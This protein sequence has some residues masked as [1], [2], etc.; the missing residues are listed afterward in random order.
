MSTGS[1]P[2]RLHFLE[3]VAQLKFKL[4]NRCSNNQAEQLAVAKTLDVT[5]SIVISENSPRTVN[6][7]TDS[8]IR[9]DSLKNVNN[10]GYFIEEIR[11]RVSILERVNW[12]IEFSWFK[13]HIGEHG[14]ELA[15]RL[16]KD[17]ARNRDT[18][19]AFNRVPKSTMYSEIEEKAKQKWQ[20]G[21]ENCAKADITKQFSPNGQDRLKLKINIT[22]VF[23]VIVTGQ[24][25]TKA[26]LHRLKI[27]D[28]ATCAC[29]K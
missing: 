12:T 9:L 8:R 13:A 20:K 11:K 16:A 7:F 21:C 18:M 3:L 29:N 22:A 5:E 4:D 24:G 27:M 17:A 23:A 14:N 25:K 26:Y 28:H 1:D 2:E 19:I 10:H 15:D 6:T